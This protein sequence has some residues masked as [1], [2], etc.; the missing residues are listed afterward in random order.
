MRKTNDFPD[1]LFTLYSPSSPNAENPPIER[2]LAGRI[3]DFDV[4][5]FFLDKQQCGK[6][7]GCHDKEALVLE[8]AMTGEDARV[9]VNVIKKSWNLIGEKTPFSVTTVLFDMAL[10]V[11]IRVIGMFGGLIA[12][13][14]CPS[15]ER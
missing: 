8:L 14:L 13:L 1:T 5:V 4:D 3:N 11:V 10:L 6:N 7:R 15:A 9:E 2:S 12:S